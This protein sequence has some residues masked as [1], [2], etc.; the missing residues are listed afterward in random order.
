MHLPNFMTF[1]FYGLIVAY[2]I[3][4]FMFIYKLIKIM[5]EDEE[6]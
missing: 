2:S 3:V 5:I 4:I 1:L 6:I